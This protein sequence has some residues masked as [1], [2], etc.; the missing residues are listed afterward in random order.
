MA[1]ISSINFRFRPHTKSWLPGSPTE[2]ALRDRVKIVGTDQTVTC[3]ATGM[4]TSLT[5][6]MIKWTTQKKT[7]TEDKY[8]KLKVA[9]K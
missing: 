8:G 1:L 7:I 5:Q 9:S 4:R 6:D 3:G 2:F